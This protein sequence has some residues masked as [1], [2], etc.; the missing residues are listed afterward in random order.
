[1]CMCVRTCMCVYVRVCVC[2]CARMWCVILQMHMHLHDATDMLV[3][4]TQ[5]RT[6]ENTLKLTVCNYDRFNWRL[7]ELKVEQGLLCVRI[8]FGC[9]SKN[10]H[11]N[12]AKSH[13]LNMCAC[14]CVCARDACIAPSEVWT[15]GGWD[16]A[17]ICRWTD[18]RLFSVMVR[19]WIS[20]LSHNPLCLDHR[21]LKQ[22]R[23]WSVAQPVCEFPLASSTLNPAAS[24]CHALCVRGREAVKK[25]GRTQ[26]HDV[27]EKGFNKGP[28]R[29]Y[30]NKT[31]E[32]K[33]QDYGGNRKQRA[34]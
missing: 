23:D 4:E 1:M 11:W 29:Q 18:L 25:E 32:R 19:F 2:V 31:M 10:I 24:Q 27:T 13:K 7:Y 30:I 22:R 5:T 21:G 28:D 20:W 33:T 16:S 12:A 15:P 34:D 14:V 26:T 3:F 9:Y 17:R 8:V 6:K